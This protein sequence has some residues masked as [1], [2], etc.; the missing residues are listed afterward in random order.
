MRNMRLRVGVVLTAVLALVLAENEKLDLP[1]AGGG[2]S[3]GGSGSPF[4]LT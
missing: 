2:S 1:Y 4:P 3:S